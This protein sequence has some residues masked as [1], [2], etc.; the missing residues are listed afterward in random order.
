MKFVCITCRNCTLSALGSILN[1]RKN[2]FNLHLIFKVG[3]TYTLL[4]NV[5]ICF[6]TGHPLL[7][8]TDIK[9]ALFKDLRTHQ[10]T[11]VL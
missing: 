11:V 9:R 6:H 4:Y 10:F 7:V 2:T 8:P 1:N 5:S 3:V